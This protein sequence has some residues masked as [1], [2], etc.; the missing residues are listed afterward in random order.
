MNTRFLAGCEG[1]VEEAKERYA[2]TM[3]WRKENDVDTILM[4]PSH[5]FTDMKE[6]FTHFCTKGST[7][8]PH[9]VRVSWR[10][11]EGATRFHGSW[12]Y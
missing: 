7:G 3:K 6:C 5:V 10:S 1:D 11:T 2:A 4:R 12:S 8:S 9:L